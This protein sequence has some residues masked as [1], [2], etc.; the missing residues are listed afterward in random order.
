MENYFGHCKR[1][2]KHGQMRSPSNHPPQTA[3]APL[4]LLMP[5]PRK[6]AR[7]A[8]SAGMEKHARLGVRQ[9][10]LLLSSLPRMT[11]CAWISL[12]PLWVALLLSRVS[13]DG[14]N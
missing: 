7:P 1:E 6:T 5:Q 12:S 2:H 13:Q 3:Q 14:V 9:L 11:K 8:N 4:V 10:W